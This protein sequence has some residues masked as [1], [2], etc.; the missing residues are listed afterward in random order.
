MVSALCPRS[1]S[2]ELGCCS[3]SDLQRGR[4]R[5][6]RHA[7]FLEAELRVDGGLVVA[8]AQR[9]EELRELP[10]RVRA[11]HLAAAACKAWGQD[12]RRRRE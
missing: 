10:V 4:P 2:T 1:G 8:A 6:L 11:H 12:G 3:C 9:R 7:R 5:R